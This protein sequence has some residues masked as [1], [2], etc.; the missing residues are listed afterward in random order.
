MDSVDQSALRHA[1]RMLLKPIVSFLMKCGMTYRE[2]I[3]LAKSSFVEVAT[4]EYG[5][6][7]RPT[8]ISRV[9]ILTGIS[10]KEVKR[11]RDLLEQ[12]EEHPGGRTTDATRVLSG[13]FQDPDF[14]DADGEPLA[15]CL[16]GQ[17]ATMT[18]LCARYAGDI[19]ATTMAKE[20]KR[21]GAVEE[22]A[23]GRLLAKRRYYMPTPFDPQ[24]IMN[25]GSIFSDLGKNINHNLAADDDHP[26]RFLGRATDDTIA[27]SAI[28][29]FRKF[30][31]ENGGP[32]LELVD[33]WLTKHRVDD[34]AGKGSV[35]DRRVRLGLGMF[36][37]QGEPLQRRDKK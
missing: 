18:E 32:F 31:E 11:Q 33:D 5:I 12:P 7:G 27:E 35:N 3:D 25:A 19:A 30:I 20:L 21:V 8:N 22:D 16:S 24:W 9:S 2:F 26:S 36:L 29:E 17:G 14:L 10:R 15:L 6:K 28:P 13:W 1:C 37:I 23:D 4:D 34:E